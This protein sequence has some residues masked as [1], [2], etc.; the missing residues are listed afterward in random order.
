MSYKKDVKTESDVGSLIRK[1]ETN[2]ISG[3]GVTVSKY[4]VKDMYDD[5]NKIEAYLNSKH[6]TGEV[7]SQGREKPFFN[8]VTAA[9]NIWYRA[10]VIKRNKIKVR[11]T[12]SKDVMD[13]FLATVHIQ[14]WMR[15]ENF[16]MFLSEWGRVLARY[17]S[18]IPEFVEKDGRLIPSVLP[19]NRMI[20]DQID[21]D[22]NPKIKVLELTEAQL[23]QNLSYDQDMVESLCDALQD[24]QTLDG[25]RKDNNNNYIKLYEIHG[26]MP[27]SYLTND[28]KDEDTYVNQMHVLSFVAS[29]D[30]KGEY[31][32]FTLYAGREKKCPQMITHLIKE[33]GQTLAMGAVQHLF[34]AQW[35]MNHTVKS[36]KDQLDLAS[37]LIFQTS[38]NTFVGQNAL[39]AIENG[40]ILIHKKDEPITQVA[41]NSHDIGSL[42][43]FASQWK[44][45]SNEITGISESM[46]G[47][48]APSGTAWRQVETLL[49]QNQ[50]LFEVMR[51]NKAAYLEQMF[52]EY[53]IPFIRKQMDTSEEIATTLEQNDIQTI[54]SAYIKNTATKMTNDA[55]KKAVLSGKVISPEMQ[56]QMTQDH[57]NA[58]QGALSQ[59]GNKRFF[60]PS[61][62]DTKT[63]KTILKDLEWELEIDSKDEEANS[64]ALT[65]LNTLLMFFAKKQ[66]QPLSPEETI[67]VNK[68]LNLTG[69]V[70]PL[71]LPMKSPLPVTPSAPAPQVPS[72][73]APQAGS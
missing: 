12:K 33:D 34:E 27:L 44:A 59:L 45:L 25:M 47:N 37:K 4:V 14:E 10:T 65:T 62:I 31:D 6:T 13:S 28:E 53:I 32:D 9:A 40:D 24:R 41:N 48:T 18:A 61:D 51:D 57:A 54:D 26:N 68:I 64:E 69:Q 5:I 29:K 7:D 39:S 63:W 22:S 71:E 73:V 35:M 43:A 30:K 56:Q 36:I 70:S 66:G 20:V 8:I 23:Y 16:Q 72:P 17:G 49:Q 38:D 3:R 42:Q 21:F 55:V 2:Y 1:T 11:P 46:L 67:V 19:W 15:R 60:K 52:R 50:S 58:V